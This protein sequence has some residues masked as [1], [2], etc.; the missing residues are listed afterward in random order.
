MVIATPP[1]C[2]Y[3]FE[4]PIS[5]EQMTVSPNICQLRVKISGKTFVNNL[6]L[7]VLKL[8]KEMKLNFIKKILFEL[9]NLRS[10]LVTISSKHNI[11]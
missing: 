1:H 8:F 9:R 3:G 6:V 5:T 10:E 11:P 7:L 4:T 2:R